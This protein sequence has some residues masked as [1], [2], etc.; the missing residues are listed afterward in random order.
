MR[1]EVSRS[2]SLR[3]GKQKQKIKDKIRNVVVV[4]D[5]TQKILKF[6]IVSH[7][8]LINFLEK[9][10]DES[11]SRRDQRCKYKS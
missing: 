7:T 2:F 3:K 10:D 1:I 8:Y 6:Y 9:N 5:G 11:C 4:V